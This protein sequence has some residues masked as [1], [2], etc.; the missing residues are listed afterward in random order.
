MP[1]AC[2]TGDGNE[3]EPNGARETT[4]TTSAQVPEAATTAD[5]EVRDGEVV[6][7]VERIEV[8]VGERVVIRVTADVDDEVHVHGYDLF[9][10]VAAGTTATIEFVTDIPGVFEIELEGRGLTVAQLVVSG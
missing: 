5:V 8:D 2:G 6:G 3:G 9:E 1:G 7:G 4:T 10:D